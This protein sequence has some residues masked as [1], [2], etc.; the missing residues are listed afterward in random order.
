MSLIYTYTAKQA[1]ED[2]IL[3][4]VGNIAK[5]AGFIIQVRITCG[6]YEL[7]NPK[8]QAKSSG[9]SYKGRL[10]DV[11][12]MARLAIKKSNDDNFAS[13]E[14]IFQDGE[15]GKQNIVT[16]WALPDTTSGPAIHIL[17]PSEN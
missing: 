4:E 3:Y 9:Q 8:E 7:V 10:W 1:V 16:M 11:L 2:G 5:E 17:L 13:F 12:N 15:P 14:V 6:V